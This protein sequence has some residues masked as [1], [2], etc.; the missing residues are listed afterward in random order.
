MCSG[1]TNYSTGCVCA[2]VE[3]ENRIM[4][5]L[6]WGMFFEIKREK[7]KKNLFEDTKKNNYLRILFWFL[8]KMCDVILS[9][10]K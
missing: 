9:F 3:N 6:D 1:L 2:V 4:D 7:K 5:C 10:L 8:M